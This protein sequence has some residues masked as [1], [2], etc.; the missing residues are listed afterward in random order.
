MKHKAP[1]PWYHSLRLEGALVLSL[2][3]AWLSFGIILV[4]NIRGKAI[5]TQDAE[6]AVKQAG[7]HA[8]SELSI[9]IQEI[10]ALT[11]TIA[12][13]S[14]HL[15]RTEAA[16]RSVIPPLLDF[17]GDL[18]IAG[19]GFWPEP[20]AFQADRDRR[21]FFWGR[22]E[23]GRLT[24]YD[25]YNQPGPG[26]HHEAWY[27]V[28][29]H[30]PGGVCSWSESYMDPYSYEPMVTCTVA[31]M[32]NRQLM[33]TAT[34][35]LKL[36]DLQTWVQDWQTEGER[37]AF[38][39]DRNNRF[40]AFP[41]AD[42]VRRITTDDQGKTTQALILA[43]EFAE[44]EPQFIPIADALEQ[45]NQHIL[46]T[47]QRLPTFD[48]EVIITLEQN[49]YQIDHDNAELFSAMMVD[50]LQTPE[51]NSQFL[52]QIRLEHDAVL[53]EAAIAYVFHVPD[54]Y[55]KLVIVQSVSAIE[56]PVN[57]IIWLLIGYGILTALAV[58][59]LA[60]LLLKWRLLDPLAHTTHAVRQMGS[61]IT[62]QDW[63]QLGK[64]QVKTRVN[65]EVG[66]LTEVFNTLASTTLHQ[67]QQL[68]QANEE[69][70]QFLTQ[71]QQTQSH[72]VQAEKMSSLGQLVAGVAH[73]INN[74]VNFIHGNLSLAKNYIADLLSIVEMAQAGESPDRIREQ[75]EDIDLA[76]LQA[77]LP[78]MLGSMR[79]GTDRI[80]EIVLSL[81]N[82]SRLDESE[83]K[84]V[85]I[86]DGINST[87]TILGN[88][89]KARENRPGIEVIRQFGPLPLVECYPG[90]LNQVF[91]N[92]MVNAIDAL[93][94][95]DKRRSPEDMK[96][97]PSHIKITTE[98]TSTEWLA[99]Q[100]CIDK[101]PNKISDEISEVQREQTLKGDTPVGVALRHCIRITITDNG[102][103]MSPAMQ[104]KV[105]DYLF[106][107]KPS[108]QGTGLGLPIS[109]DIV[110]AR[111]GGRLYCESRLGEGTSFIIDLPVHQQE[112]SSKVSHQDDKGNHK[113]DQV[114]IDGAFHVASQNGL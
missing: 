21:S 110:E 42:Q 40:L 76:F 107:T 39:L 91:M 99:A 82:F 26:Y 20:F 72:L 32:E 25:D 9:R 60:Y 114:R 18:G 81:R 54:A 53:G 67:H 45:I 80:R 51:D 89:L 16:F 8:V 27:V 5:L 7:D 55:W 75:A 37:Y 71:L 69:L 28:A 13:T 111:H 35:D 87:L 44:L 65:N 61:A 113:S 98:V 74:P 84:A 90:P 96:Q 2:I 106:T 105:F 46:L 97:H 36:G 88:R 22:D 50:P 56:A 15:P 38:I 57:R 12:T 59:P 83:Y 10:A 31:V 14:A 3:V 93:D 47:A 108:G 85:D 73:E 6:K 78:R 29:H 52:Q 34:V 24:Y 79:T 64:T 48:P 41:N 11:R 63:Q 109:R 101:V 19:G 103:G 33:G 66:V 95:Q 1:I 112:P 92:L 49:S 4:M 100:G 68:Q 43:S 70:H 23:E 58:V 62:R 86:H 104:Q 77:D 17:N 102:P 30:L 94:E